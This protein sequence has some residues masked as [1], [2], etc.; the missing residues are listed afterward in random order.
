MPTPEASSKGK[1]L[2]A[3]FTIEAADGTKHVLRAKSWEELGGWWEGLSQ[4]TK[5][6]PVPDIS[7]LDADAAPPVALTPP[8]GVD[9]E[10]E[11]EAQRAAAQEAAKAELT[12]EEREEQEQREMERKQELERRQAEEAEDGGDIGASAAKV[13]SG[14]LPGAG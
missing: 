1:Q 13:S 4:F 7:T 14:D 5:V 10:E 2:E 9:D 8:P 12:T 11:A 6:A 3:L